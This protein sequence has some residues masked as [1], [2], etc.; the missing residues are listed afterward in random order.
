MSHIDV[1]N[2]LAQAI[3]KK[4]P[5]PHKKKI[6]LKKIKNQNQNQRKKKRNKT[7]QFV[8]FGNWSPT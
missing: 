7:K 3:D 6:K 5:L 8:C 1:I 2:N 4:A